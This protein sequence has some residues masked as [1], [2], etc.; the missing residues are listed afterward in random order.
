M[1]GGTWT[2]TVLPSA[3]YTSPRSRSSLFIPR[4]LPVPARPVRGGSLPNWPPAGISSLHVRH[5]PPSC[6]AP[7]S[8]LA[9][10]PLSSG[11][12]TSSPPSSP[13]PHSP[14]AEA[15]AGM[16]AR[17]FAPRHSSSPLSPADSTAK[18]TPL[19]S[20]HF[21]RAC[22]TQSRSPLIRELPP[23]LSPAASEACELTEDSDISN[24]SAS[25]AGSPV[26]PGHGVAAPPTMSSSRRLPSGGRLSSSG[27]VGSFKNLLNRWFQPSN[28]HS[29][30]GAI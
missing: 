4:E 9:S 7:P 8:R 15:P 1:F 21:A 10:P 5:N 17:L 14:S 25:D 18:P 30:L 29:R 24:M 12:S 22:A 16:W 26:L 3:G 28:S 13:Y 2:L 27:R 20:G 11:T 19:P 6:S 23:P